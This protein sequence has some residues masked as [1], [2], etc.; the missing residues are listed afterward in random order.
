M[1]IS[2]KRAWVLF[3]MNTF[4]GRKELECIQRASY[5]DHEAFRCL[6]L[7]YETHLLAYLFRLLG[8]WEDA[9][10]VAQETFV[11]AFFALPRWKPVKQPDEPTIE[12]HE[13]NI[14]PTEYN[15]E[16]FHP[17]APWLYR[18]ATNR[19]L[20][21]LKKQATSTS[22]VPSARGEQLQDEQN[23]SLVD[24]RE[25][26]MTLEDRYVVRELLSEALR[27]LSQEDAVCLV[28]RFVE[29]EQYNE[30]AA[31]LGLTKEAV[32]KRISRGLIALRAA[33]KAL[34]MEDLL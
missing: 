22:F 10:D 19:A 18:I 13:E 28:L 16:E 8:N 27:H 31:R 20:T 11:A 23:A 33:Y 7:S 14:V 1:G 15:K 29:D 21:L 26:S 5:G 34:D 30:I 24:Q 3:D 6:V 25:R 4:A 17:L 2:Q 9:H 32:R 12:Q